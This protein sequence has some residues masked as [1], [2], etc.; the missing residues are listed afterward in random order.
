MGSGPNGR[1]QLAA[2]RDREVP[3]AAIQEV[4]SFGLVEVEDGRVVFVYRPAHEHL[5]PMGS[6]HGGVAMTLL[7]S[8]T[9][10][11]VHTTLDPGQAYTTLETKVQFVRTVRPDGPELR[12]EGDVVHRGATIATSEAR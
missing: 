11:A 10:A 1:E 9:G 4:L 2:I 7:D 8:A 3:P 5:N 6:V 12:A